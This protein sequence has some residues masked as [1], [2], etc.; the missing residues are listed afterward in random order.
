VLDP[1]KLH[2]QVERQEGERDQVQHRA[3]DPSR[4]T[5]QGAGGAGKLPGEVL[6]TVLDLLREI[7][8]LEEA[9]DGGV[10]LQVVDLARKRVDELPDLVVD[11]IGDRGD[12]DEDED[13]DHPEYED[14]GQ[15]ASH[16]PAL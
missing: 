8:V 16:P 9:L 12:E 6:E 14:R 7:C 4:R 11:R 15:A 13:E 5:E 3:E 2:H 10:V 1:W